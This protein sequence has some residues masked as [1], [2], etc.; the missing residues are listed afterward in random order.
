[1]QFQK[2][3]SFI[4]IPIAAG[5]AGAIPAKL[6]E[7]IMQ[8]ILTKGRVVHGWLGIASQDITPE[9][10][11]SFGLKES[12]GVLVSGV[13]EGGPADRTG[14]EPGDVITHINNQTPGSAHSILNI[15]ALLT[16]GTTT[17]VRG[18]RG[19]QPLETE[20]TISERLRFSE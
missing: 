15:I 1:M 4:L 6:A 8:Q 7:G 20:I 17:R 9:L 11:E 16:P 10:A 2:L 13:L 14:I 12:R 18:W 3:I 19:G 5:L